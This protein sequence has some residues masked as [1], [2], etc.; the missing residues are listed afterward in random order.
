MFFLQTLAG[1]SERTSHPHPAT[2]SIRDGA[3]LNF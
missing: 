3:M 1:A 2:W